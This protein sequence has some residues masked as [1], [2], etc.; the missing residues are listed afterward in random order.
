VGANGGPPG[1]LYPEGLGTN[2]AAVRTTDK[3]IAVLPFVDLSEGRNQEYFSDGLSD[4]LIDRLARTG[5]L[6]VIARTS[7]FQFKGRN[8]DVRQIARKLGVATVLEG[9]VRRVG[10][11]IR[12]TAQLIKATDGSHVWSQ[13][14][15]RDL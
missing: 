14:Y 12:V 6:R 4:E 11:T 15:D 5:N 13:T 10:H 8:E 7:S 1:R 9:S 3:S 2:M